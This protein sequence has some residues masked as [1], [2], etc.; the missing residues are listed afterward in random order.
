M[1]GRLRHLIPVLLFALVGALL[2]A[3]LGFVNASGL[4][5]PWTRLP[6]PP[7]AGPAQPRTGVRIGSAS[8][9]HLI[10]VSASGQLYLYSRSSGHWD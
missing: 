9:A 2:G 3:G 10:L 7:Q 8:S 1:A 4:L 6:T 5:T